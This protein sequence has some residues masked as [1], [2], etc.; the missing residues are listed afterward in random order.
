MKTYKLQRLWRTNVYIDGIEITDLK[1]DIYQFHA[2]LTIQSD[3]KV[4]GNF[5]P[6]T[7][8]MYLRYFEPPT[9]FASI[10]FP[11]TNTS[12]L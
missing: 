1:M 4:K 6:I 5:S 11:Q 9:P 8:V 3:G 2:N 7:R 10:S 12:K